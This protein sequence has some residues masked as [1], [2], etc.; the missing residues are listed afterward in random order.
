MRSSRHRAAG[1]ALRRRHAAV[2]RYSLG[3]FGGLIGRDVVG[4][5]PALVG[6]GLFHLLRLRGRAVP[7]QVVMTRLDHRLIM[8]N[9]DLKGRERLL[10]VDDRIAI[11]T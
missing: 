11:T 9:N 1:R 8:A 2:S 7:N 10:P 3:D 5:S 6:C 4:S